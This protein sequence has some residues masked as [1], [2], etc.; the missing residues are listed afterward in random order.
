MHKF[1]NL[2]W[3][4]ECK[5]STK[6]PFSLVSKVVYMIGP[7]YILSRE[8]AKTKTEFERTLLTATKIRKNKTI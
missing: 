8:K 6:L 3:L 1:C 5:V 2:A 7:A 4:E